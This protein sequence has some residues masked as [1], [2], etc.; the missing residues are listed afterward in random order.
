MPK[1]LQNAAIYA[2]YRIFVLFAAYAPFIRLSATIAARFLSFRR[3]ALI[4][5]FN[6]IVRRFA[7]FAV[8]ILKLRYFALFTEKYGS[9][10]L[11]LVFY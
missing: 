7:L 6:A 11:V 10:A 3:F 4:S 5:A 9:C 1:S 2:F 8:H